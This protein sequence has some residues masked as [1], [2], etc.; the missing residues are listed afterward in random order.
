MVMIPH[1][2][3]ELR[4]RLK[5]EDRLFIQEESHRRAM[6]IADLISEMVHVYKDSQYFRREFAEL[7]E[8]LDELQRARGRY[9]YESGTS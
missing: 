5:K 6:S 8:H 2:R 9:K 3:G 4:S 7:H 1:D